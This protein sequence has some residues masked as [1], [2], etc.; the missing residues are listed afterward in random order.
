MATEHREQ[1]MGGE[2][3]YHRLAIMAALSLVAMYFLMYAMVDRPANIYG[4]LNQFFMAG[5]MVAPMI[6]IELVV[7]RGMYP[8][9]TR[10]AIIAIVSI[11][12]GVAMFL[13]IRRQTAI[14]DEQFLRSMIPHHSGAI[15]MCERAKLRDPQLRELC[16][17][18]IESQQQEIAE[19][20][21]MLELGR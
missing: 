9:A 18:I 21:A 14:A 8:N 19:M 7:M 20:T 17:A 16:D 1:T 11:A 12:L 4:N 6:V 2:Q 15:L 13:F 3:H 5:L 10:N